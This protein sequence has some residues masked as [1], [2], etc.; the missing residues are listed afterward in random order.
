MPS[1]FSQQPKKEEFPIKKRPSAVIEN[2][3]T[4]GDTI[5]EEQ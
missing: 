3:E 5:K 4:V 2:R 1:V